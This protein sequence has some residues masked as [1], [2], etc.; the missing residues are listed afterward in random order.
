MTATVTQTALSDDVSATT[1]VLR[2]IDWGEGAGFESWASGDTTQ[3]AYPA[4][5]GLYRPRVRLVDQAG[6]TDTQTLH[7][8][9]I[10]DDTAPTGTFTAG[11]AA[12]WSSLT[13][14]QLT[15]TSLTDDFSNPVDVTRVVDWG[16]GSPTV[17][18][19]ATEVPT[20]VYA[21]AGSYTPLVTLTD[22]AGNTAQVAATPVVGH[23]R[24]GQAGGPALPAEAT[25]RRSRHLEDPQGPGDRHRRH[26]RRAG[27]GEGR[28]E[29]RHR[30]VRL[31]ADHPNVGQ[32]DHQGPRLRQGGHPEGRPDGHRR[33]GGRPARGCARAR[34]STRWSRSTGPRTAPPPRRT[35]SELTHGH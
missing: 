4:V 32:D 1:S 17:W 27:R 29:A 15:Q 3:H 34:S 5:D 16:D 22:E 31:Q 26:R 23:H 18:P 30:V 13:S 8:V 7:A 24:H 19:S 2:S 6:N 9:V 28:A 21:T 33:L 12:A 20:H 11:P 14:V 10:G 35:R 25:A